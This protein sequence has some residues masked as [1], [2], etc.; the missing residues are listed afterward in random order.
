MAEVTLVPRVYN[1]FRG[2][3]FRGEEINLTRSPDCLNVWKDY[4][5]T[6]SIR[7][8]PAMKQIESFDDT[9]YG[10]FFYT[11]GNT[12]I[13]FVHSGTKLYKVVDG[14]RTEIYSGL[15]PIVSNSFVHNNIWYFK[16]GKNYLQYDGATIKEVEGFIPTTSINRTPEGSGEIH[17]YINMLSDY[18]KNTFVGDE[19]KNHYYLDASDGIDEIVEILVDGK[20]WNGPVTLHGNEGMVEF[21]NNCP[22]NPQTDGQANVEITYKKTVD[23][24]RETIEKCTLLQVFDNRVFFSGNPD[25]PNTIFNCHLDDPT[26]CADDDRYNDGLDTT[27][28][29]GMAVRNNALWVFK[30]PTQ[31][32]TTVFYHI[33]TH[34]SNEGKVYPSSHS[35]ITTGC[36]GKAINFNGDLVFFSNRGMEGI[37]GDTSTEQSLAHRS[38]LVDSKLVSESKYKDMT[39]AE[40]QGYLVVFMGNKAY[41]ADSRAMFTNEDHVEYDWFYWE[42][43]K[44]IVCSRVNNGDLFL[45]TKD[46]V[47]TLTGDTPIESYWV[48]PK[49][50]FKYPNKLK[51]TNKRGCVVEDEGDISVYAKT[52]STGYELIGEYKG[53]TDSF[54]SRIKRKK[55]KDLQLKFY[56]PTRFSL[57]TASIECFIG[58]Y[59]KR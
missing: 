35:S 47:Y 10:I 59:I 11:V 36:V 56:S 31:A 45:G 54:V 7:T 16:D 51:T 20:K 28:I 43:E 42:M 19:Q 32:N 34:D 39:L 15:N 8:R 5:E 38:T 37:I 21:T 3:D 29:R 6:D 33:P 48:T 24:Y 4:K 17:H 22:P 30:V 57:E 52:E 58:G 50:K 40:W 14:K 12:E 13:M 46:G 1:N 41:L 26:Y 25:Y 2:A 44:D 9:V 18:R 53:I 27:E 23:G 55:F 49:D